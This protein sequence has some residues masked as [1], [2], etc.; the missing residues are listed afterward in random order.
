MLI[1]SD[2]KLFDAC[3]KLIVMYNYEVW[4]LDSLGK[5]RNHIEKQYLKKLILNI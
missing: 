4:I 1:T 2:I 3:I 5:G